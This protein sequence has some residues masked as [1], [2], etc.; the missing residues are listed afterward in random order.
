V[1]DSWCK[2]TRR[3]GSGRPAAS[4]WPAADCPCASAAARRRPAMAR[5]GG[6]AVTWLGEGPGRGG[7][8]V[9]RLARMEQRA[10]ACAGKAGGVQ[11]KE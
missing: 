9:A 3:G 4:R 5:P 7:E 6:P 10:A 11:G 1:V 8:D 2:L